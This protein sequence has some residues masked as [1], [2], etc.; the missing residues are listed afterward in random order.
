MHD[1]SNFELQAVVSLT[2][3]PAQPT[4][5]HT[6]YKM[7]L[8]VP[9]LWKLVTQSSM[10]SYAFIATGLHKLPQH[11]CGM[12][13]VGGFWLCVVLITAAYNSNLMAFLSVTNEKLPFETLA[14]V[15]YD[16]DY[17]LYTYDGGML[18][19]WLQVIYTKHILLWHIIRT[20][21]DWPSQMH[22]NVLIS[23]VKTR[24]IASVMTPL[25]NKFECICEGHVMGVHYIMIIIK[26]SIKRILIGRI[27]HFRRCRCRFSISVAS[28]GTRWNHLIVLGLAVALADAFPPII[29]EF[30]GAI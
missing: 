16:D 5:T 11:S 17:V 22:S 27:F 10:Y 19:L 18:K 15:V 2:P 6:L 30:P 3:P 8:T 25:I 1:L 24:A 20:H 14:G 21:H 12:C 28:G 29:M 23:R 9:Y 26:I 13:L 7:V 4:H